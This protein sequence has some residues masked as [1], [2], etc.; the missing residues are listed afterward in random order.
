MHV[1][2]N[3]TDKMIKG[4]RLKCQQHYIVIYAFLRGVKRYATAAKR[5]LG[6]LS[7]RVDKNDKVATDF[8]KFCYLPSFVRI[9]AG[10]FVLMCMQSRTIDKLLTANCI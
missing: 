6:V 4:Y 9:P 8:V 2:L 1:V 5:A 3:V 10:N 7:L